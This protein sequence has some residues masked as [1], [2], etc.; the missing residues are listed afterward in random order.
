MNIRTL[1]NYWPLFV[2]LIISVL[3]AVA[4]T[5]GRNGNF[6]QWMHYFMG[7]FLCQFALI[8]LFNPAGFAEG[9]QK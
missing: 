2:L 5:L 7:F 3:A 1:K 8:K 6:H 9:F 4:I